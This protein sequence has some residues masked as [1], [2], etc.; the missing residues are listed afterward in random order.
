[1]YRKVSTLNACTLVHKGEVNSLSGHNVRTHTADY[2]T[3]SV[4]LVIS[5]YD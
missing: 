2:I 1:M 3:C 5:T 4:K